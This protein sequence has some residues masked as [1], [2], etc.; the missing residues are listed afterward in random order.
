MRPVPAPFERFRDAGRGANG[1]CSQREQR[2]QE[3]PVVVPNRWQGEVDCAV[4]P[5]SG[6]DVAAYFANRGVE[7][8]Q[9][10]TFQMRI[11]SHRDAWFVAVR[12][13]SA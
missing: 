3:L 4:G 12:S 2:S 6:R 9:Y 10:E 5:F 11:F 13:R 1:D 7:F 8:G